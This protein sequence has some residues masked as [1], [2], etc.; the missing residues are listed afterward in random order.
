MFKFQDKLNRFHLFHQNINEIIRLKKKKKKIVLFKTLL[1]YWVITKKKIYREID[2][3][4]NL[5][6]LYRNKIE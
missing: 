4:I 5:Q 1:Y 3:W 2:D 6:I